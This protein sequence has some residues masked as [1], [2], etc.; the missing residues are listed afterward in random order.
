MTMTDT[1]RKILANYEGET[2]GVKAQLARMLMTGRL[3]G[4]G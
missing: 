2:P 1:V 4:T 3:A